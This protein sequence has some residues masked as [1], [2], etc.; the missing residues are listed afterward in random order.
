MKW[1]LNP[2]RRHRQD[3]CLLAGGLLSDSDRAGIEGHLADCADCRRY[4]GQIKTT[5]TPLADW[6]KHFAHIQP[7]AVF[8]SRVTAAVTSANKPEFV[9]ALAPRFVLRECWQQL[10][11]PSR[12]IWAGLAVVWVLLLVADVS[13]R[14]N[15]PASTIASAPSEMFLSL[16]QQEQLLAEL[17]EP[18]QRRAAAPSKAF[19]PRPSSERQFERVMT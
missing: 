16:P 13:L 8:Q 19:T 10:V 14:D 9:L 11:W 3:L 1:F 4:Y 18:N 17:M 5:T 15:S 2:C 6:E 7:G 12:R